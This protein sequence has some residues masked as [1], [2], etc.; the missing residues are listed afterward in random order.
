MQQ[1]NKLLIKKLRVVKVGNWRDQT[2]FTRRDDHPE[3]KVFYEMKS[4]D[5]YTSYLVT[6]EQMMKSIVQYKEAGYKVI[7]MEQ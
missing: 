3:G 2:D 4:Y 1:A 5:Q 7:L 6:P